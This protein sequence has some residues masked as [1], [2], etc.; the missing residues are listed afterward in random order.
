MPEPLHATRSL[1]FS[2]GRPAA[3]VRVVAEET[4]VALV[5]DGITHAVMMA[6]PV[7]LED[8]AIGF[9]LGEGK[10]VGTREL[11]GLETV[12]Q[13]R[14]IELRM[15]LEP[16]AGMRL[17]TRRRAMLGPTA[18][19][20]CGVESLAAALPALPRVSGGSAVR[21]RDVT[22]A[23]T[24]LVPAQTLNRQARALHAAG[25][26][27]P[28]HGLVSLREDVGRHNALDKLAGAMALGGID[29][30]AGILVLTSRVSVEMVQKAAMLGAPLIAAVSAPTGLAVRAADDAGITLAAIVRQDGFEVFSHPWR[31][32]TPRT[33]RASPP[34][35][36]QGRCAP[37]HQARAD[38][39]R[40]GRSGT[41]QPR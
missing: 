5:Y 22:A 9:S 34:P 30:A 12:E 13:D 41:S 38:V 26:W 23:M 25:F 16:R 11:V 10:I 31:I 33:A 36:K 40:P 19:G 6:T 7:D 29:P 1:Q 18:C 2:S 15:W 27:M 35:V 24:S 39:L 14:G 17:T 28:G 3:S 21:P 37:S 8:F 20:L 32:G 4:P